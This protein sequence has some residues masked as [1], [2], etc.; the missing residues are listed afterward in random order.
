MSERERLPNRRCSENFTFELDG[1][2]FT[3][4]MGRALSPLGAALGIIAE[5]RGGS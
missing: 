3:A 5:Q 2:K 4:T 1:L